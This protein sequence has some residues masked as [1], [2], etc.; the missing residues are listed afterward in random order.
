MRVLIAE[1]NAE[2]LDMLRRRLERRGYAVFAAQDGSIAI[3]Q[4]L[5]LKPDI[6]LMDVSMPVLS[7]LEATR[8][9]RQ[10]PEIAGTPIVA[11]TAHAMDGDRARCLE[12]GCDAYAT[13]PVDLPSLIATM[14]RLAPSPVACST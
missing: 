3:E 10:N 8:A 11:L 14:E 13:K 4:T 6:V 12:A 2:N 5:A 7:G 1:D 9:I